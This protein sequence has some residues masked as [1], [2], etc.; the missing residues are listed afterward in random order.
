MAKPRQRQENHL[1]SPEIGHYLAR[2]E[3]LPPSKCILYN[4]MPKPSLPFL[5]S[6]RHPT[7]PTGSVSRYRHAHSERISPQTQ[8]APSAPAGSAGRAHSLI[9]AGRLWGGHRPAAKAVATPD[10]P[11]GMQPPLGCGWKLS[12]HE[13][14]ILGHRPDSRAPCLLLALID[15]NWFRSWSSLLVLCSKSLVASKTESLLK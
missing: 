1:Y 13:P 10:V 3:R 5:A 15:R 8:Q 14:A 12:V 11:D 6:K 7:T 4:N 9:S 2:R